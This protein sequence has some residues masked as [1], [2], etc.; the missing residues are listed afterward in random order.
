MLLIQL[1]CD[2]AATFSL[3]F[4]VN[5]TLRCGFI[6]HPYIKM[7]F[8]RFGH[9]LLTCFVLGSLLMTG[10]HAF[11]TA[12]IVYNWDH[13]DCPEAPNPLSQGETHSARGAKEETAR[14]LSEVKRRRKSRKFKPCIL[15][16]IT[17]NVRSLANK[18]AKLE[19]LAF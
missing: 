11:Y 3:F 17:A 14:L 5:C 16:F 2:Q 8:H 19:A 6:H 4:L 7:V 9:V 10:S 12:G 15:I 13:R 18:M 1:N